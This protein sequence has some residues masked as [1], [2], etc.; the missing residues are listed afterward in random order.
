LLDA[1]EH[2]EPAAAQQLLCLLTTKHTGF[3]RHPRHFDLASGH[4]AQAARQRGQ[5][6]LWS[7][8]AATGEEP[9]SL[10]MALIEAFRCDHPPAGIVATDLDAGALGV[11]QRGEY[12]EPALKVLGPERRARFFRRSANLGRWTLV[13]EVCRLVAFRALNLTDPT[14]P[15]EGPFDVILC[16]NVLM[17]LNAGHRDAVS[18][19]LVSHL[20][21]DGVLILDPVEQLGRAA[22]GF[23]PG[24]EGVYRRRLAL[25]AR[26]P[27][28]PE[29][30]PWWSKEP[31]P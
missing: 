2:G 19:R 24:P 7:A 22:T 12:G 10:A 25:A 5:A 8:G 14:W 31:R 29:P 27:T 28:G 11:A 4:A 16:R 18:E 6:R 23:S 15:V 26:P 20:A 3:F 1:T 30:A 17:Y 9:Y 13:P 21:P